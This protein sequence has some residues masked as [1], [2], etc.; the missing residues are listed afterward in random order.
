M[1]DYEKAAVKLLGVISTLL[2]GYIFY[3]VSF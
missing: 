3:V 1:L 2:L